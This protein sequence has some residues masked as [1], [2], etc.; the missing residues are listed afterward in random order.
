MAAEA[1]PRRGD[2]NSSRLWSAAELLLIKKG[3]SHRFHACPHIR[4]GM[5][6]LLQTLR[7][8]DMAAATLQD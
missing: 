6:W 4:V 8:D 7:D 2:K 5:T 1:E 3:R